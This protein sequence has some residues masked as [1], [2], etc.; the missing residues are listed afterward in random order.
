MRIIRPDEITPEIMAQL[1]Y[2]ELTPEE[3]QEAYAL[4]RAAFTA[5]D[6]QKFTEIDEGVLADDVIAEMEALQ[7]QADQKQT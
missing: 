7:K 1:E 4:G 6:L 5:D 2:R 3:L